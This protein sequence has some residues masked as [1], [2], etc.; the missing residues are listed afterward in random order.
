MTD[1]NYV[2]TILVVADGNPL[3]GV[4]RFDLAPING[5]SHVEFGFGSR[6][7]RTS[8]PSR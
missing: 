1:A 6:R 8:R 2:K 3:P 5:R 4:A 7:P